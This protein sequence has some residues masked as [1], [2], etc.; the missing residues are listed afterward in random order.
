MCLHPPFSTQ[1]SMMVQVENCST[2]D[3]YEIR[4][5]DDVRKK[6]YLILKIVFYPSLFACL[7]I[8]TLNS[9]VSPIN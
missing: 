2:D 8:V 7:K 6:T 1:V 4:T 5:I 9:A 3:L